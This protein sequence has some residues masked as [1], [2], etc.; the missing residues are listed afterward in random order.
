MK[1]SLKCVWCVCAMYSIGVLVT[2]PMFPILDGQYRIA[3]FI[4]PLGIAIY[5]TLIAHILKDDDE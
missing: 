2:I 5:A 1:L 4:H 3:S